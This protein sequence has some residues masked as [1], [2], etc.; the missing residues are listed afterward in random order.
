M[1]I[2]AKILGFLPSIL[3]GIKAVE[4]I[5]G[6]GHGQTK[7]AIVLSAVQTAAQ[8]GETIDNPTVQAISATIDHV[9][10][11]LNSSGIFTHSTPAPAA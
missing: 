6:G 10:G 9:V 4:D 11:L 5:V 2:F 1:S 8:T 7:K 3:A